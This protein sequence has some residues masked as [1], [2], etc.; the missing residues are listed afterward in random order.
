LQRDALRIGLAEL[1]RGASL[2]DALYVVY[3]RCRTRFLEERGLMDEVPGRSIASREALADAR[4]LERGVCE[5]WAR[6]ILAGHGP[7]ERS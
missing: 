3:D 1:E 6:L 4:L 7:C 2:A 5:R